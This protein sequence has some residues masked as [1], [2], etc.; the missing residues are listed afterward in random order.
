M[1]QLQG[2]VGATMFSNILVKCVRQASSSQEYTTAL[3]H[4]SQ[5]YIF[6]LRNDVGEPPY[7]YPLRERSDQF[8]HVTQVYC[9]GPIEV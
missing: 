6:P 3:E 2:E 7:V 4:Y 9:N 1:L 5:S 8:L